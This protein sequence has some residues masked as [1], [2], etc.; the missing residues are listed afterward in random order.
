ME[1]SGRWEALPLCRSSLRKTA[2]DLLLSLIPSYSPALIGHW[3]GCGI[4]T[5]LPCRPDAACRSPGSHPYSG[6]LQE[7]WTSLLLVSPLCDA[8]FRTCQ[9]SRKMS[10]LASV[11]INSLK[12]LC[13]ALPT[14]PCQPT[15]GAQSCSESSKTIHN[16][17]LKVYKWI[18]DQ[19]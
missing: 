11:W 8:A 13:P 2:K 18:S 17:K 9:S 19:N 12:Y 6:Q 16:R 5:E 3:H 1:I 15:T 4:W 7:Q 10:G 14:T